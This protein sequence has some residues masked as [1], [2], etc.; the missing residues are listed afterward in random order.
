[1]L[2][3]SIL[4]NIKEE[5]IKNE[6]LNLRNIIFQETYSYDIKD[7]WSKYDDDSYHFLILLKY[8]LIVG[9]SHRYG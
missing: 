3:C 1:M 6:I 9:C 4:S 7:N 2:N 5:S 8:Y